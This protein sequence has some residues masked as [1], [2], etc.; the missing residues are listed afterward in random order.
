MNVFAEI[1]AL[2]KSVSDNILRLGELLIVVRDKKLY[3]LKG[4]SSFVKYLK[5]EIRGH[6]KS[7]FR[8]VFVV[9]QAK[10]LGVLK[11]V[12]E[13]NLSLFRIKNI[14]NL[15][16]HKE[17][18]H[19]LK[20]PPKQHVLNG[21]LHVTDIEVICR[22]K[23]YRQEILAENDN[24]ALRELLDLYEDFKLKGRQ[25]DTSIDNRRS[26]SHS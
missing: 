15:N 16:D 25:N 2:K 5:K 10:N 13:S 19:Y 26:Y 11:E 17:V 23:K 24:E 8:A 12:M 3:E 18:K 7:V 21:G 6:F 14:L 20:H 9:E 1:E 22:F 4:Y